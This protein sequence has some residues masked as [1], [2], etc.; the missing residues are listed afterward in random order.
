MKKLLCVLLT[1][2]LLTLPCLACG[3]QAYQMFAFPGQIEFTAFSDGDAYVT[4]NIGQVITVGYTNA[5]Y[6]AKVL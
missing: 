6:G 2:M 3:E 1:M 4:V 5:V